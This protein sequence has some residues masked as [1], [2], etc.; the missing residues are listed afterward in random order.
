MKSA[1]FPPL[2]AAE[3][4][5]CN[6][7]LD[8]PAGRSGPMTQTPERR[9]N[10]ETASAKALLFDYRQA[11]NPVRAGLTEPIPYR[12]WGAELHS[13]GPS[14]VIPLDL[15]AELGV[16]GPATSPSL[17][18][19][20]IRIEAGEGVRAAAI[21]TS[22]LFFVLSGAGCCRFRD[23]DD[24]TAIASWTEGDLFVLPA[25][26]TPLLEAERTS[27]LYWVHDAPLLSYLGVTPSGSRFEPTHY[28]ASWLRSELLSLADQPGSE[29][30]NRISLLLANRDLPSTRTVTHVLWAMYGIV[31]AGKT[32][33]PHR[34]QSVALDLIINCH[35]GVYTLVGTELDA[36]GQIRNPKRIDWH[37]G[38]AFITPPGH[39]HSHVNESGQPAWFLPIQDAG[40]QTY[41]RSL[42]IRFA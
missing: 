33:P 1:L 39:W 34:H 29:S 30:S 31:P 10:A 38:G 22:S 23:Q 40:L 25:G 16:P 8:P 28:S 37:S 3:F 9:R 36:A 13:T 5:G 11:A 14:G 4:I 2:Q 12:S 7:R 41:L 19:H 20:F 17:A 32:Q 26:G 42:D 24:D 27:V 35:P 21:A 18:A 6:D 15:S